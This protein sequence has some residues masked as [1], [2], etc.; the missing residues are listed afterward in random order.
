MAKPGTLQQWPL[1]L[2]RK[3]VIAGVADYASRQNMVDIPERLRNNVLNTAAG[4]RI[5]LAE[6]ATHGAF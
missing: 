2:A 3:V 1:D 4:C 6:D 5:T